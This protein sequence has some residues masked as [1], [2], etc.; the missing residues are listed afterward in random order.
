MK[1]KNNSISVI[2]PIHKFNQE[3][4]IGLD[5]CIGN[6]NNQIISFEE[7]L[8][9][10]HDSIENKSGFIEKYKQ[11]KLVEN[12]GNSN[13]Q[14]QV[15]LG[16]EN[17]TTEWFTVIGF[18]DLFSNVWVDNFQKYSSKYQYNAYLPIILE[19]NESAD[20]LGL[21][22]EALWANGFANEL[23]VLEFDTVREYPNFDINGLVIKTEIF[24]EVGGLKESFKVA[25]GFEFLLRLTFNGHNIFIIPKLAYQHANGLSGSYS[26]IIK[27]E[28]NPVEIN[29]WVAMAKKDY[30]HKED[31]GITYNSEN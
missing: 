12:T 4:E 5:A 27:E 9:V 16:V 14:A 11:F 2:I 22:N 28:T 17:V 31:K 1:E 8:I 15:N 30:I 25:F 10:Y 26:K 19:V 18:D 13:Y 21:S 6:I 20:F 29:W 3:V 24:K 23:G 7:V